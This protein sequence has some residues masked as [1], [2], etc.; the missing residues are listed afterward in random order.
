MWLFGHCYDLSAFFTPAAASALPLLSRIS[1]PQS[2]AMNSKAGVSLHL[3]HSPGSV[4]AVQKR[5][6]SSALQTAQQN[7]R[8]DN[9]GLTL[10]RSRLWRGRDPVQ[11]HTADVGFPIP[12]SDTG[13]GW[14]EVGGLSPRLNWAPAFQLH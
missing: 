2:D 4:W 3:Q 10:E 1:A 12:N 6:V 13:R 11:P 5:S 7:R 8:E 9:W 14:G